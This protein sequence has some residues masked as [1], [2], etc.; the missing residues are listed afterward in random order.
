MNFD[1]VAA[2]SVRG[3]TSPPLLESNESAGIQFIVSRKERLPGVG[4]TVIKK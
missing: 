4:G 3:L 1:E 2:L